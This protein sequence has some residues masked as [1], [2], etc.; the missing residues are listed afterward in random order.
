MSAMLLF[1]ANLRLI[2]ARDAE[3]SMKQTFL[4]TLA[5]LA[6]ARKYYGYARAVISTQKAR[7]NTRMLINLHFLMSASKFYPNRDANRIAPI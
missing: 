7:F 4:P 6:I 3:L 2:L 5:R 1:L